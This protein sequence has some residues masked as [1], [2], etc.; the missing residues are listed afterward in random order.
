MSVG[1]HLTQSPR[2]TIFFEVI[3]G[4]LF[5]FTTA[6]LLNRLVDFF[7]LCV[8]AGAF[9]SCVLVLVLEFRIR[10][11][12][13]NSESESFLVKIISVLVVSLTTVITF[14]T[15]AILPLNVDRSF[16]VWTLNEMELIGKP[17]PR[18]EL[19]LESTKFFSPN[20]GEISRRVDEQIKLGNIEVEDG[21]L[22]LS[23]RGKLQV[24]IHR[25]LRQIFALEL[26]YTRPR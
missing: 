9:A 21:M 6:A 23:A 24:E 20:S 25:V 17:Q 12:D 15:L 4:V 16:S 1:K 22:Q 7:F 13:F 26:N 19:I 5:G 18:D 10:K 11:K 8:F 14:A 2:A 3:A